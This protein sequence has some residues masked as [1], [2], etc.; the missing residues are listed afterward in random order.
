M[1]FVDIFLILRWSLVIRT[2]YEI[3]LEYVQVQ[4]F[5]NRLFSFWIFIYIASFSFIQ[6]LTVALN[7]FV[8]LILFYM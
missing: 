6:I 5:I 1:T 4:I 8:Y 2:L 3:I 7:S